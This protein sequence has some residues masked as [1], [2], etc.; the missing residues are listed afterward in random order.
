MISLFKRHINLKGELFASTFTYGVSAFLRLASS[1]V[2]TR[3]LTPAAYGIFGIL[4]SFLFM[5]EL[6]SDVGSTGLL[7]RHVRG[8]EVAFVHTL[9]TIRLIRSII[10]CLIVLGVAP[11]V[12]KI[13]HLPELTNPLRL[14]S[15][16]FLLA[17][18]ESMAYILAQRDQ[19]ARISNY[20]DMIANF[21]MTIFVIGLALVVR[22]EYALILSAI[23]RRGLITASSHFYY[24]DIGIGI[25][26][27]REAIR[28]QF[29]FARFVIPSSILT[30]L[31]SQYDKLILLKLSDLSLVGVYTIAGNILAPVSGL[32]VHNA[33]A[34][35]YPRLSSYFRTDKTSVRHRYYSENNR[36]LLVGLLGPALVAGFGN[37]FVQVLYDARYSEAGNILTVLAFGALFSA[38]SNASENMLVASGKNHY[39]FAGNAIRLISVIPASLLGFHFYGFEGFLWFNVAANLPGLAYFF[40][41]QHRY[42]L[43]SLRYEIRFFAAA[44]GAYFF[45]AAISYLIFIALPPN[46]LHLHPHLRK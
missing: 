40:F 31:L 35:L 32:I 11:L 44:L 7:I 16:M 33:R 46:F 2:L 13:Y 21:A 29:R 42:K 43:L 26:F 4:F 10:N 23:F 41:E 20:A 19:R 25:A 5:I 15:V 27:D 18:G 22:N 9:W 30:V 34:V 39:V 17:G 12:A 38:F 45:I 37:L 24:R 36:L 3:L 1:L 28:E 14:L 8:R 6:I